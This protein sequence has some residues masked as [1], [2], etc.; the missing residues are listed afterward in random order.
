MIRKALYLFIGGLILGLALTSTS[1][2]GVADN[3]LPIG[4]NLQ[5][6]SYLPIIYRSVKYGYG[7]VISCVS[8]AGITYINGSIYNG[9]QPVNGATIVFAVQP[10]EPHIAEILSGPHRGYPDWANGF[11]SIILGANGPRNGDWY[12]WVL[13]D[14]RKQDSVTIHLHTDGVA[15]PGSCQQGVIKFNT[16]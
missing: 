10:N 3:T 4:P 7:A 15:K 16:R 12:F 14:K 11:F 6:K 9:D 2:K 5:Y 13:S 1:S 8:N